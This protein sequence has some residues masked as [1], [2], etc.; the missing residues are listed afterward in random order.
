MKTT[1][2]IIWL[3]SGGVAVWRA[4]HGMFKE[5]FS[6][7]GKHRLDTNHKDG[8]YALIIFTPI[9]LIGGLVTLILIEI[10][11]ETCWYFNIKKAINQKS[12]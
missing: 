11:T 9:Y 7:F 10:F 4:Y 5:W 8:Y 2:L 12:K 1:I 6:M 3:L